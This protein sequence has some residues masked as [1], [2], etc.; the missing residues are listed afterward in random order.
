MRRGAV[1]LPLLPLV[2]IAVYS[3]AVPP[4][5]AAVSNF[6]TT[7]VAANVTVFDGNSAVAV[8]GSATFHSS[9]TA[10]WFPI[11]V[12]LKLN[13][14]D[15]DAVTVAPSAAMPAPRFVGLPDTA[16]VVT[17]A[18]PPVVG[19]SLRWTISSCSSVPSVAVLAAAVDVAVQCSG[20]DL[21]GGVAAFLSL[22]WA[23]GAFEATPAVLALPVAA[24]TLSIAI[25]ATSLTLPAP[26]GS[27]LVRASRVDANRRERQPLAIRL[28][29]CLLRTGPA[30]CRAHFLPDPHTP[31]LQLARSC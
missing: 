29:G 8:N 1:P 16:C 28:Y 14:S 19:K 23:G 21:D 9:I 15:A 27:A 12:T 4:A 13:G 20:L 26:A 18:P 2:W 3:G 25:S 17:S 5:S 7:T 10:A 31:A 6:V 11:V 24:P 30:Q 22:T